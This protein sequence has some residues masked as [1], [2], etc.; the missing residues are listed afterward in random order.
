LESDKLPPNA[1]PLYH[2]YRGLADLWTYMRH[3]YPSLI[4]ENCSSGSLRQELTA[5]TFTDTHW[6]SDN[7]ENEANLM[8]NFAATYLFPPS[9]CSHWTTKPDRKFA[10]L[11][12][13]AQFA[14]NMLGHMG[15]SGKIASWDAETIAV[16]K[17][18]IAQYKRIR[19]VI[20]NADV[21]H[22][23]PQRANA[24]QAALY[25]DATT[26]RSLLFAFHG[27]D[28]KMQH[29]LRLRG[30]D[31]TQRYRLAM[32]IGDSRLSL[33]T[34]TPIASNSTLTGKSLIEDGL[35]ITFSRP[36]TAAVV[37]MEPASMDKK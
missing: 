28:P 24:M 23:T 1:R 25:V 26:G 6:V 30:L 14:I 7:I 18:R 22:L 21:Y 29:T 8:M 16:A 12:L 19:P 37:E 36:G 11:D 15:L 5:A 35:T 33:P 2:H 10:A 4:I 34:N 31:P 27:N 3:K 20:G 9:A 32:P 17:N 13:D